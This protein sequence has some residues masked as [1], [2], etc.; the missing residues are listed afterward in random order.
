MRILVLNGS[1][2]AQKSDTM[3]VTRAFLEG[4]N[5]CGQ[6]EVE[7][8][9]VIRRKIRPCTGC[10]TCWYSEEQRCPQQDDM[11][12]VLNAVLA[13]D[14]IVW[15]FPLYY[16]GMPSH[17]KAVLDRMLPLVSMKME[18]AKDGVTHVAR[19]DFSQKRYLLISGC[20][21]PDFENHFQSLLLQFQH[22]YGD[23]LTA[24]TIPEA[25]MFHVPSAAPVTAPFLEKVKAAGREYG[26]TGALSAE[27]KAR[28][29]V[30]MIPDDVYL[31]IVNSQA[32]N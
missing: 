27:T 23:R 3:C 21:F 6:N 8:V 2:K 4:L 11:P 19:Y 20:G 32:M 22:L 5:E 1:P 25:P 24:L 15:S 17:C 16:Y 10:F 14:L 13:A 7:I 12:G 29:H 9:D 26:E 18:P 31:Q 28:L 30:P